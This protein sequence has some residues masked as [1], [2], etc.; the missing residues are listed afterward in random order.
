MEQGSNGHE[1]YSHG[2]LIQ[3]RNGPVGEYRYVRY[4]VF[5][6]SS[7]YLHAEHACGIWHT[8]HPPSTRPANL[9]FYGPVAHLIIERNARR[10]VGHLAEKG[11]VTARYQYGPMLDA[12]PT[13][14]RTHA[15]QPRRAAHDGPRPSASGRRSAGNSWRKS[16]SRAADD[17][18]P[19]PCRPPGTP[20]P[21]WRRDEVG[22]PRR[23]SVRSDVVAA[24]SGAR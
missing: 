7:T 21:G 3:T 6:S 5:A 1:F 18:M 24:S 11:N 4:G 13:G 12:S 17:E 16:M 20:L 10:C 19:R 23:L 2:R 9:G 14:I 22:A 15:C 8:S